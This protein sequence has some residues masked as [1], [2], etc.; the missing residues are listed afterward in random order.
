M[1]GA[2]SGSSSVYHKFRSPAAAAARGKSVRGRK[3]AFQAY[4]DPFLEENSFRT[5][6]PP[7]K[8]GS[9]F[10]SVQQEARIKVRVLAPGTHVGR[11]LFVLCLVS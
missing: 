6:M 1:S 9:M 5:S 7:W 3:W 10:S 11:Y 2:E 4:S 8:R